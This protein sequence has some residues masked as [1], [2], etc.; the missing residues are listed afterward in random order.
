M[1]DKNIYKKWTEFIND[2]K[3]NKYFQLSTAYDNFIVKLNEVKIYINDNKKRPSSTDENKNIKTM[4]TWLS[5]QTQNYK[6]QEENMKDKNFYD[7]WTDFINNEN[8]KKYFNHSQ[9]DDFIINL[10]KIK[11]Y[12]DE[13]KKSPSKHDKDKNIKALGIWIGNQTKNYNKK[14]QN[15]KDENIYNK[16][17]EFITDEKYKIYFISDENNWIQ[18]LNELKKYIDE[19]KKRPST[20]SKDKHIKHLGS[21]LSH[22]NNKHNKKQ[23]MKDDNIYNKWTEF[24]ND[25]NYKQYFQLPTIYDNFIIYLNEAKKYIDENNERPSRCSKDKNIKTLGIWI[26]SQIQNYKKRQNNMKDEN[27]YKKW[28][29]FINDEKYKIYFQSQYEYFII[30]LCE[31]KKYIDENNKRPSQKNINN[32]IKQLGDWIQNQQI[33]YIKKLGTMKDENICKTWT[34]FTNHPNY[35][36]YFY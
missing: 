12:I 14:Q 32:Y 21:W 2:K 25:K 3:Y 11:K 6:K 34:E 18:N 9:Y 19:F 27:I 28:N 16:W 36:K 17:T 13:N 33:N 5:N 10:Q 1:K 7:K 4:G 23:N 26:N 20:E 29:E 30:N 22:Q 8:Y 15:M 24:I 31:V 35:K